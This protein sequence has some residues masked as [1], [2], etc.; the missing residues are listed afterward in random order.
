MINILFFNGGRGASN[1]INSAISADIFKITSIVNAYDDGKSTGVIRNFFNML[2]PSDIRK[3]QENFIPQNIPDTHNILSL[4]QLRFPLDVNSNFCINEISNF[5]NDIDSSLIPI[6]IVDKK[7]KI[8]LNELINIFIKNIYHFKNINNKDFNFSD[9]SFLNCLYVGAFFKF[10]NDLLMAIKYISNL[11]SLNVNILPNSLD[12]KF[13]VGLREDG[14]ML[15]SESEIVELRSNVRLEN[16][17]LLDNVP[18]KKILEKLTFVDKQNYLNLHNTSINLLPET[19]IAIGDADIIVYSPGTQHSSL[20][21]T[22]MTDKVAD[23]ISK[24]TKA[25]KIFITN[26]GADYESP[27]YIASEYLKNAYRYL[28]R[29]NITKYSYSDLFD[30]NFVNDV[31]KNNFD[32][33]QVLYD[34]DGFKDLDLDIILDDF[35]DKVKL[36][37]HDGQKVIKKIQ[38]LYNN[39]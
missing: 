34:H 38:Q 19:N 6:K 5:V 30:Y 25:L 8:S 24:N 7:L 35:E 17:F 23:T 26:I 16:I 18:T 1:I 28:N 9:C 14:R 36:G 33:N 32:K 4:F 37:Q 12:N 21:P 3:V 20:Y 27:I 22:Y 10:N 29:P 13:L 39:H 11:F 15:Y 2:G 31:N